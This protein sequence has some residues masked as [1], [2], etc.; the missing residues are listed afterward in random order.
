MIIPSIDLINGKAVQLIQ[1]EKK[2]IELENPIEIAK[3]FKKYGEIALI[4][5]DSALEKGNNLQLIKQICK[6]ADCRV[7]GGIRTIEKAKEILR[8]GAKKIIIGT[9]ANPEFLKKLPKD[10][11]IVAIDAKDNLVFEKGWTKKTNKTIKQKIEELENFCSEFLFTDINIEG[12]MSGINLKKIK[13]IK[14]LTKNKITIAGGISSK[15]EVKEL[16]KLNL[17]SQLGMVIYK[18][19]YFLKKAF[20]N[21]LNFE[22]GKGL[23]PTI[24]EDEEKNILMLAYSTKKSLNKTFETN[25][26]TYFSRTRNKIWIKGEDSGNIQEIIKIRF[27]C[28]MDTLKFTVK[29]KNVACHKGQYSCFGDKDFSISELYNIILD[30]KNNPDQNSYTSKIIKSEEKIK[31][32]IIEEANEL[33]NYKNKENL[34]WEA[35]DLT[36]FVIMLIVKKNISLK[37]IK[38]ELRG[39]KK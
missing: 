25:K 7:G 33:I 11:I 12:T 1:G 22:K 26:A 30:R 5:L 35:A 19:N 4:D 9:K 20:I 27:D 3:D 28:D 13:K 31:E 24:V 34:V 6:I 38:N 39:R 36:Y 15:K 32:K 2:I 16:E 10:K 37:E 21:I 18:N 14:N 29:Q 8:A 23:I 17:N